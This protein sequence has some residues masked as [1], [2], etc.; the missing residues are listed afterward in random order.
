[1]KEYEHYMRC[2]SE[3]PQAFANSDDARVEIVTDKKSMTAIEKT[4]MS[5]LRNKGLPEEWGEVGV[6]FQDE[7]VTILRDAVLFQPDGTPGTYIRNFKANSAPGVVILPV[8]NGQ[9]CLLRIF[10]HSLRR[11]VLEVPR[12]FGNKGETDEQNA[13]RELSEEIKGS[14]NEIHSMGYV[15]ENSGL[16]DAR[17][18]LFFA[19]LSEMPTVI[20]NGEGIEKIEFVSTNKFLQLI[21]DG[22]IEDSYTITSAARAILNGYITY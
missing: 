8:Y 1:M 7:Y 11:Y 12:G 18:A 14:V 17:A 19:D 5:R 9:V 10:R 2:I 13:L 20:E 16:G 4:Q 21:K 15:I 3:F 22:E 6:V